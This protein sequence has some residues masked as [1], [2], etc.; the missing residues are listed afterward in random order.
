MQQENSESQ[1]TIDNTVTLR[2]MCIVQNADSSCVHLTN[3]SVPHKS[4]WHFYGDDKTYVN[5]NILC[6][7]SLVRFIKGIANTF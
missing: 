7:E 1:I 2:E 3:S 4:R 6:D 5:C